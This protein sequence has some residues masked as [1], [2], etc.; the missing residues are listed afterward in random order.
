M[1]QSN[2]ANLPAK[3]YQ[4]PALIEHGTV[5]DITGFDGW[6]CHSGPCIV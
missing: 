3:P 1:D 4:T 2:T 5:E 6:I